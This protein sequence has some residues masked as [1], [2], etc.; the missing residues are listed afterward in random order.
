M[1]SDCYT[2]MIILP[3][4]TNIHTRRHANA[5][6][7][8]LPNRRV[9][10]NNHHNLWVGD[11]SAL[12]LN[13]IRHK[14]CWQLQRTGKSYHIHSYRNIS[15]FIEWPEPDRAPHALTLP[16]TIPQP[17]QYIDSDT[18]IDR[19]KF[20]CGC[21]IVAVIRHLFCYAQVNKQQTSKIQR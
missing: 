2:N 3:T 12:D 13:A 21:A 4:R 1:Y 17:H 5:L 10:P 15:I 16:L 8:I 19:V 6:L 7:A 18:N 9:V 14:Y 20:P 11:W